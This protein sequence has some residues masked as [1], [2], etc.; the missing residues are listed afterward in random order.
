MFADDDWILLGCHDGLSCH[1]Q[2]QRSRY[3]KTKARCCEKMT[4]FQKR[5]AMTNF[6]MVHSEKNHISKEFPASLQLLSFYSVS[7]YHRF[8]Y[9]RLASIDEGAVSV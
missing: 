2:A 6:Q 7:S 5:L 1:D 3:H 8:D 9:L 4:S